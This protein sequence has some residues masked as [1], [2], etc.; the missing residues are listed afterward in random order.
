[1]EITWPNADFYYH[2]EGFEIHGIINDYLAGKCDV[3]VIGYDD[4]IMDGALMNKLCDHDLVYTDSLA[5]QVRIA[6]PIRSEL[7]QGMSYWMRE[8]EKIGITYDGIKKEFKP[9]IKCDVNN[10]AIEEV[11]EVWTVVAMILFFVWLL[12]LKVSIWNPCCSQMASLGVKNM[13]RYHIRN[14]SCHCR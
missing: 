7:V 9:A 4:P 12:P 13:V 11:N 6:M 2:E 5:V 10:A 1:M 8:G 14:I 3:M